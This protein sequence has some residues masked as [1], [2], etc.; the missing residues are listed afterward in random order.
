[1]DMNEFVEAL[2]ENTEEMRKLNEL[3]G[4][5]IKKTEALQEKRADVKQLRAGISKQLDKLYGPQAN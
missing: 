3:L 4:P 5:A 1:M 2:R